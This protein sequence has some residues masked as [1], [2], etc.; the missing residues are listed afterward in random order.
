MYQRS[1]T[2]QS[3]KRLFCP[4][5][6]T[7]A[8][9]SLHKRPNFT[10]V[11]EAALSLPLKTWVKYNVTCDE[12][13]KLSEKKETPNESWQVSTQQAVRFYLVRRSGHCK[14]RSA[15]GDSNVIP[16]STC[17]THFLHLVPLTFAFSHPFTLYSLSA[18]TF[19][20][21]MFINQ[22]NVFTLII[23]TWNTSMRIMMNSEHSFLY[24]FS[25]AFP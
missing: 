4:T 24:F 9:F 8:I 7:C 6:F 18:S 19:Q 25:V 10:H 16:S 21:K 3:T 15:A 1:F 23:Y 22:K 13:T 2:R 11:S 20:N 5:L 17:A 14:L 12:R